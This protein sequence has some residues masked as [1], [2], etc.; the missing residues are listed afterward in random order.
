MEIHDQALFRQAHAILVSLYGDGAAFRPGQY[1]AIEATMTHR[2]TLVVQRT[3]WGKSLVYFLSTRLMRE[4][5]RGLTLVISPLLALMQNQLEAA[6]KM[7]LACDVL[8]STVKDR[9]SDILQSMVENR[10]DLVLVTPET[11]FSEDVQKAIGRVPIGLFVIDEAHCISDWGHDFRLQ[12]ARLREVIQL[13]PPMVPVLATTATANNRVIQD[14]SVQLGER[15]FVSRGPLARESLWIQVLDMPN[16]IERYAWLLENIPR[17]P[18]SGIIYCLTQR[19]CDYLTDFLSRHGIAARSYY[20]RNGEED[21]KNREAEELFRRNKIKALVATIK[22]GMGYDKDDI[23]FVIH[24]QMPA[25]IVSYYQQIGRAGRNIERAYVVLMHGQEDEEIIDYFIRTAFPT[26]K[27]TGE[28][29]SVVTESG[30]INL[31]GI[32]RKVNI[33]R[34]RMEKALTFLQNDGFLYKEN[35]LYYAS[36]KP[37]HYDREHYDAVTA[38]RRQEMEQMKALVRTR[39]CYEQFIIRALDDPAAAP[40]GH[41]VHCLGR[42]FFPEKASFDCRQAAAAYVDGMVLTIE[43]RKKWAAFPTR[44]GSVIK[45]PNQPGLCLSKYGDPGYGELVKQGKYG[46]PPRFSDE[47]VGK[48]ASLLLPLIQEK[49]ITHLVCVPSLRSDVVSDFGKRLAARCGL[50]WIAPLEKKPA[51]PQKTMENSAHQCQN[52]Y[53]SF[54]IREEIRVP[55]RILLVDDIVDS[56]WTMTVCGHLLTEHGCQEVYPFALAD[57]SHKEV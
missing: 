6:E 25:N 31:S 8:N 26:E 11:L 46:K 21:E 4:R 5:G 49:A 24:F 19:D 12:Y 57:S 55:E 17:M 37:Y 44:E 3:G 36:P 7:G 51:E 2:R 42:P 50:I 16:K 38:I 1:E 22:L 35:R 56:R 10:L 27:E 29:L 43:P 34:A 52:A 33:S 28:V 40:C 54:F 14:L 41:C 20:S 23:A 30:G 13:L 39:E 45:R 32:E 9:R 53:E 15:V 48:S 47:L 18:G